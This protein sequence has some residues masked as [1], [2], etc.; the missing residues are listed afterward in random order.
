MAIG[1]HTTLA[2]KAEKTGEKHAKVAEEKTRRVRN[3]LATDE[4]LRRRLLIGGVAALATAAVGV[5]SWFLFKKRD[6]IKKGLKDARDTINEKIHHH[7]GP[8]PAA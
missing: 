4:D 8:K 7:G 3:R 5:G 2:E 6:S 1:H